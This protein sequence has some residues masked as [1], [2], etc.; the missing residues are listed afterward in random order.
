MSRGK[1]VA[2]TL[3]QV[4]RTLCLSHRVRPV[5]QGSETV[6]C[7][8]DLKSHWQYGQEGNDRMIKLKN[9]LLNMSSTTLS[10][11]HP[12]FCWRQQ[13]LRVILVGTMI[14]AFP[15]AIGA[16]LNAFR[17]GRLL[18]AGLYIFAYFVITVMNLVPALGFQIRGS[19]LLLTLYVLSLINLMNFGV[20][21]MGRLLLLTM[22]LLAT[23]LFGMWGG[24]ITAIISI[25]SVGVTVMGLM[26][27]HLDLAIFQQRGLASTYLIADTITF[28]MVNVMVLCT[29][30]TL[31]A[32]LIQSLYTAEQ[33]AQAARVA[34]DEAEEFAQQSAAQANLLSQQTARLTHTQQ[35][36]RELVATLETPAVVV[37]QRTLLAPIVGMLDSQR[38]Q[39]LMQRLLSEVQRQRA[40][41][42][43][44]DIAGVS[45]VES[46]VMQSLLRHAQALR[47]LGCRVVLTGVSPTIA[48]TLTNLDT[49]GIHTAHSPQDVLQG[50][51][52][53]NGATTLVRYRI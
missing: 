1:R 19:G 45:M 30:L 53:S 38:I 51:G 15:A 8:A 27:G 34:R 11:E 9:V 50:S 33:S 47:L 35:Q 4:T 2:S 18:D 44:I 10:P 39:A 25:L 21:G 36:L 49:T 28:I 3:L 13:A 17:E 29:I 32:R 12:L 26:A 22:V 46:Q 7:V 24:I 20:F 31:M 6:F 23:F 14:A 43:I 52:S 48:A 37:A 42:V 41:I 40:L 16:A 5:I